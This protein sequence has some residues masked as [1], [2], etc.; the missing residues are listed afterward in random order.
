MKI[1]VSLGNHHFPTKTAARE[2]VREILWNR[3]RGNILTGEDS[4]IVI[5]LAKRHPRAQD[6]L[7][8]GVSYVSVITVERGAPG[9][10]ITRLDGTEKTFSYKPCLD[11]EDS[12]RTQVIAAMRRAVDPQIIRW[13]RAQF[14]VHPTY[15]CRHTGKLLRNDPNTETDHVSPTFIELAEEYVASVGGFEAIGL[16]DTDAHRGQA[17]DEQHRVQ[18]GRLHYGRAIV[19]LVHKDANKERARE[20]MKSR[21]SSEK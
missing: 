21:K 17:L 10:C 8:V 13:R 7:G 1:P 5:A 3:P 6:K 4:E 18:F 16:Y 11:G 2:R 20:F 15:T 14:A 9:F 19:C 12:H